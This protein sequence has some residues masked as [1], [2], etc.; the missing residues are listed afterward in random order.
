MPRILL[1]AALVAVPLAHAQTARTDTAPARA[2]EVLPASADT[3]LPESFQADAATDDERARRLSAFYARHAELLRLDADNDDARFAVQLDALVA[4]VRA[5][6]LRSGALSDLRF[7]ELYSSVM[8]EYERFYGEPVIDRGDVYA[9]RAAGIDAI[10]RGFDSG[11]PLLE[12]VTLPDLQTFTTEIPMDVNPEVERYV[13]FLLN[14]PSHVQRLRSRADTYFP[15]VE[16]IMAE[17]GVPDELKYLAMVES[18]L[19]PTARSHAA[20]VGMWQ[21]ISATGRAYGLRAEREVDDRMDPEV[22]TRAAARHLRDLYDRFGDW[23]LALA[24]YNCNPAVIARGVR[25]FEEQTGQRATFWDIDHVIPRETRAYV[26]MFIATALILSNPD[27]YGFEAHE[28]G[29]SFVFDRIPVA[30]GTR[31]STVAGMIG[32]QEEVLRALNPSLRQGRVPDVRVPH[33]LRIPVGSY[34]EFAADLDG[35]APPEANTDRWAAETVSFG[36]RAVRPL[37]PQDHDDAL[38]ALAARRET[39]RANQPRRVVRDAPV[40]RYAAAVPPAAAAAES[41]MARAEQVTRAE[42]VARAER[43]RQPAPAPLAAPVAEAV[44][45]VA[46]A[47]A[48]AAGRRRAAGAGRGRRRAGGAGADRRGRVGHRRRRHVRP[49]VRR[50]GP[51][52]RGPGRPRRGV[53]RVAPRRTGRDAGL[54]GGPVRYDGR[55]DARDEPGRPVRLGRPDAPCRRRPGSHRGARLRA[56]CGGRPERP[57]ADGRGA[58]DPHPHR[59]RHRRADRDAPGPARGVPAQDRPRLRDDAGRAPRPQPGRRDGPRRRPAADRRLGPVGA[60]RR[61]ADA[62]LDA[63]RP[64]GRA[65]HRAGSP[66]RRLGERPPRVERPPLRRAP[67]RPAAPAPRSGL[68]WLMSKG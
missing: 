38:V 20:A 55:R 65:P 54:A 12:H 67:R 64:P 53:A 51:R 31:L 9:V 21:F 48:D 5:A 32:V 17:E 7:R 18:A 11:A 57:G 14:R 46:E 43:V 1:A 58:G 13:Q 52:R 2:A 23:Q 30:G 24:G 16:R 33:Q 50:R 44:A 36:T 56:R 49:A 41:R 27:A 45:P 10:E 47:V 40:E 39:R 29:P 63:P 8:T 4:D 37:A 34:A 15:M 42:Q 25:R 26:P 62:A 3:R 35:L 59:Q 19:N 28:P 66:V 61:L 68:A 6:S 60:R 22:A